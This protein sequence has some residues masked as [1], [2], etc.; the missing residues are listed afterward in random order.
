MDSEI[1]LIGKAI[2]TG[3]IGEVIARGIEPEHFYD[4]EISEIYEYSLD[5][6]VKY[7]QSPSINVIKDQFPGFTPSLTKDPLG[8]HIEQFVHD[9]RE[10]KAV[11]LV[12]AYHDFLEDPSAIGEIEV[13]A[14]DMARELTNVVPAPKAH[15]LSD[16]TR[17]YD[18]YKHR[19]KENIYP[20]IFLGIPSFDK[21]TGG[22]Q[23]HEL[24][25]VAGYMGLGKT[26]LL[27]YVS[28]SAYLQGKTILFVSLE[29][30]ADQILR[31][32]DVMLSNVRYHALKALELDVGEEKQWLDIL[33]QAENERMER[34]IIVRADIRNC[35]VAKIASETTRYKP[36]VVCVDY[37]EE[38]H[39]PRDT[40]GWEAIS[41]NG[42]G[43]KQNARVMQIPHITA[44]QINR[45]GG[46]GEVTLATLGY[47]SIGKQA[48]LL[49]GLSQDEE[50]EERQE[51][52]LLMLKHRDGPSRKVALM[53]WQLER[54]IIKEKGNE[55]RFP[56]KRKSS[57]YQ[58]RQKQKLRVADVVQ[59]EPNPFAKK[60]TKLTRAKRKTR[61]FSAK[62]A[63]MAV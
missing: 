45:E 56:S 22:I 18:V 31:K 30:E 4:D 37:L 10:R 57:V 25:V 53:Q 12:R 26:T 63:K 60:N 7:K 1:S 59:D 5:F 58:E 29:V 52:K 50:M 19:K 2:S 28:M 35:T 16:G 46:K 39:S 33:K 55:D 9:V 47:Q 34:D 61:Q 62:R 11:E 51:M 13:H 27:Q 40:R 38:M 6:Y 41:H 20:G 32:F 49:I 43:L 36:D 3:E 44:T 8:Y 42:R 23:P 21:I 14:L 17:R 54:G 15:R 48:D 24:V